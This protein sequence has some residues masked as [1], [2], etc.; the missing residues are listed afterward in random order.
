[1]P[2]MWS[3]LAALWIVLALVK[4]EGTA[5]TLALVAGGAFALVGL[6]AALAQL[7]RNRT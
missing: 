7:P 1:M 6:I 3:S 5:A 4:L 2:G